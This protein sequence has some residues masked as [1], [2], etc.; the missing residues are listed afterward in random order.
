M[1]ALC[2][3]LIEPESF[4]LSLLPFIVVVCI[5]FHVNDCILARAQLSLLPFIVVVCIFFHVNDCILARAHFYSR[6]VTPVIIVFHLFV[7]FA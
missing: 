4:V 5:F 3:V 6:A 1:A 7:D 2:A